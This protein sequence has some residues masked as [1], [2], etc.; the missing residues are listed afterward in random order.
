MPGTSSA[1][2][3]REARTFRGGDRDLPGRGGPRVALSSLASLGR[4]TRSPPPPP[5]SPPRTRNLKP[6]RLTTRP[7]P[8]QRPRPG[9]GPAPAENLGAAFGRVGHGI[10]ALD[11]RRLDAGSDA[12]RW[13]AAERP[14]REI[15]AVFSGAAG[16]SHSVVLQ[17]RYD[18]ML[19]VDRTTRA[20]PVPR[21]DQDE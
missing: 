3:L 20:R 13:L 10:F 12:V 16:M 14:M 5:V 17:E 4:S 8:L 7:E 6:S 2:E 18:A 11:L 1:P 21:R 9:D 15:G 19:F